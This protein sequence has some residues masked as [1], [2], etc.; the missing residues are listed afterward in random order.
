MS[1]SILVP[2]DGSAFSEHALPV[3]LGIARARG[4]GI[5]LVHVHVPVPHGLAGELGAL[6]DPALEQRLEVRELDYLERVAA[7]VRSRLPLDVRVAALEGAVVENL[8]RH[9]RSADVDLIVMTTHGRGGFER[10]WLGSVA[11]GLVRRA[12]I[13]LLLIR[14][15][16]T[17]ARV[18]LD[19]VLAF[20][21]VLV[22]LDG[23]ELAEAVLGPATSL[24]DL[25]GA[26][27]TLLR[28][29]RPVYVLG[30]YVPQPGRPDPNDLQVQMRDAGSYLPGVAG[31]L[32]AGSAEVATAVI[33]HASPAAG[34][35]DFAERNAVD[36]I[37]MATHGRGG[38]SR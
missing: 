30:R 33:V 14:N 13:P 27:Y 34:I 12:G 23:S 19:P 15:G 1:K 4:V 20:Q 18:E 32:R 10:A 31:R 7:Q 28:V 11:D 6:L 25:A 35:L 21:H 3:A 24:G 5:H 26:G 2:L 29:I 36:L 9:A 37:A 22:P 16:E 8:L 38:V 17:R